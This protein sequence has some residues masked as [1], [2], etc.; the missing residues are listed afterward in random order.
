[1]SSE[2]VPTFA[3]AMIYLITHRNGIMNNG[4][5]TF[6]GSSSFIGFNLSRDPTFA[7][8]RRICEAISGVSPVSSKNLF[9]FISHPSRAASSMY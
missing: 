3:E 6:S 1:M 7:M 5:I 2:V 4:R 9:Q 8:A